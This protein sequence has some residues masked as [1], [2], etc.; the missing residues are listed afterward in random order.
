MK[1]LVFA[2]VFAAVFAGVMPVAIAQTSGGVK[3]KFYDFSDQL[4]D[5]DIK[6]PTTLFTDARQKV[7]F[8]RLLRL[9]KSFVE[10][11]LETAKETTFK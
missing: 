11:M 5:G 4:I 9:K 7:K 8:D 2:I 3:S 6:K 1:K 10:P